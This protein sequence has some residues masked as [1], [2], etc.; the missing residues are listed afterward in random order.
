[1][2][3][4]ASP[5][6]ETAHPLRKG[7]DRCTGT[8]GLEGRD[9]KP[10]ISAK[11]LKSLKKQSNDIDVSLC[12]SVVGYILLAGRRR[13]EGGDSGIVSEYSAV[14]WESKLPATRRGGSYPDRFPGRG[15][16]VRG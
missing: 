1:M 11:L 2:D 14:A 4:R 3:A 13:W 16:E 15:D 7:G 5:E 10:I 12:G 9:P 6:S 8:S